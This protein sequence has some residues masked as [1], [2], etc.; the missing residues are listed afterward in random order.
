MDKAH[1]DA[2]AV[3]N[4]YRRSDEQGTGDGNTRRKRRGA[5]VPAVDPVVDPTAGPVVDLVADL[6]IERNIESAR[7]AYEYGYI[8]EEEYVAN[9]ALNK[10]NMDTVQ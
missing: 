10:A 6:E 9:I 4:R 8:S 3:R 7:R 5:V 1:R 2:E